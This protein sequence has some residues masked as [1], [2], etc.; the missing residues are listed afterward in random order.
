M[1]YLVFAVLHFIYSPH[2]PWPEMWKQRTARPTLH[3]AGYYFHPVR[4]VA[5]MA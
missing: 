4:L 1:A 3:E 5:V 2:N